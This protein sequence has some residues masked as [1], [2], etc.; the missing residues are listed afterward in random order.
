MMYSDPAGLASG[1]NYLKNRKEKKI[2]LPEAGVR[3]G[4]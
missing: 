4:F 1:G 3:G 2:A